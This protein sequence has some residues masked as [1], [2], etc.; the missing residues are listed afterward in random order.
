MVMNGI[1][2][3]VWTYLYRCQ[4]SGSTTTSKLE[5]IMKNFFPANRS[6]VYPASE[7]AI[8]PLACIVHFILSRHPE[9]G[10]DLCM[11]LIQDGSAPERLTIVSQ[12][13][14]LSLH[15]QEREELRPSWPSTT[16]F[17]LPPSSED[18]P[19][20]ADFLPSTLASKPSIQQFFDRYGPVL[21]ATA[22]AAGNAVGKMSIFDEQ[23]AYKSTAGAQ[24]EEA[25]YSYVIHKHGDITVA[26]PG[27]FTPHINLLKTCFQSWPRC[28]HSSSL[29]LG[30]AV[31]LLVRCTVHVDPGLAAAAGEALGRF[32]KDGT[33]PAAVS[34]G[35]TTTILQSSS[36]MILT[37]LGR[38]NAFLF[39][40][41]RVA[42]ECSGPRLLI[43]GAPLLELW[44]TLVED[45]V[46]GLVE[47][48]QSKTNNHTSEDVIDDSESSSKLALARLNEVESGAL[49]LISHQLLFIR[50]T[51]TRILRA[52]GVLAPHL[53]PDPGETPMMMTSAGE[54]Q[55]LR[56]VELLHGKGMQ[57]SWIEEQSEALESKDLLERVEQLLVLK[58]PSVLLQIA[59]SS[60]ESDRLLWRHFYPRFLQLQSEVGAM[61]PSLASLRETIIAATGKY[62]AIITHLAGLSLRA[63]SGFSSRSQGADGTRLLQ[64][65]STLVGQ[66][67]AWIKILCATA[68]LQ[69][70]RPAQS[71]REHSRAPSDANSNFEKEKFSTTRGLFRY[72]TPFLDS[73]YLMFRDAAV[74]CVCI[75]PS[76]AYPQLLE[77]LSL[78]AGRQFYD[79]PRSKGTRRHERLH[80]AVARIY[81]LTAP[82]LEQQRSLNRQT[83][84]THVLK[85]VRNTQTF[86]SSAEIRDKHQWQ[87]LRRY[88]CGT[89]ERLFDCLANLKD[90]DRFISSNMHLSLYRLC[91]EWCQLGPQ[92]DAVRQ[93]L[94]IMQRAAS[95]AQDEWRDKSGRFQRDTAA[96][97][98]AAVGALSSLCVRFFLDTCVQD[99]TTD[100]RCSKG[101]F[102]HRMVPL[103]R[104]LSGSR[105]R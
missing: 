71:G 12:A 44:A 102:L 58:S 1:M 35:S 92:Q 86:L 76:A 40:P 36:M 78:L 91:E 89:V 79:D 65:H 23:W 82:F 54:L 32:V 64:D 103:V 29:T 2:R 74:L 22:A 61:P 53:T 95:A 45:W 101:R 8:R 70:S 94:V 7:D 33:V 93:R 4:E 69:E 75:F 38:Y 30:D 83:A 3:L 48:A 84:L 66:W 15:L 47:K 73:E 34:S 90:T 104:P 57:W 19:I 21:A 43:E 87:L 17:A 72:L 55:P 51:G 80:S 31:D 50:R 60:G 97:S 10:R 9:F 56:I 25:S 27:Q 20:N 63:P 5:T 13:I 96:L 52:L 85:F 6:A 67:Y 59:E 81:Y 105:S 42:R 99:E 39:S 49:F 100:V 62:V 18:Y 24:H 28:L 41:M 88:F 16:D 37:V 26:Y 11:D 68:I 14:L 46:N 77:D 98:D